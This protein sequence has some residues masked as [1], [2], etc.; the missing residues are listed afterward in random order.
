MVL[1]FY[2]LSYHPIHGG[3]NI[4]PTLSLSLTANS[5]VPSRQSQSLNGPSN[6][7]NKARNQNKKTSCS[8]DKKRAALPRAPLPRQTGG[9]GGHASCIATET[10]RISSRQGSVFNPNLS[11]RRLLGD[12][13]FASTNTKHKQTM[14]MHHRHH[15]HSPLY[16]SRFR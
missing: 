4:Y 2:I 7:K 1:I 13:C 5:R 8:S 15:P 12:L 14:N 9:H 3:A 6:K 16:W 10:T 11:Q